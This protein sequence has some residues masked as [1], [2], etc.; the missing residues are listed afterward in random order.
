MPLLDLAS[1]GPWGG[2]FMPPTG[3]S[4]FDTGLPAFDPAAEAQAAREAAAARMTR[5]MRPDRSGFFQLGQVPAYLGEGIFNTPLM[6][7]AGQTAPAAAAPM[8]PPMSAAPALPTPQ[9]VPMLNVKGAEDTALPENSSLTTT[10]PAFPAASIGTGSSST[11][12]A[13]PQTS[14][15]GRIGDTINAHPLTLMALGA[16]IAGSQ[17]FG[18]GI[19]RG[20][21]AA[22]PAMQADTK[23]AGINQTKNALIKRG[24][25]EDVALAASQN[26]A[27]LQQILPQIFGA[28]QRKFTQIGEDMLGNK[29]F[30]FVDEV[31]NKVYGMD[32]NEMT[33]PSAGST[34]PT[35]PD[36]QPL[37]GQNLLTH[38]EKNDP[39]TAAG[40]KGMLEGKENPQSRNLQK[41]APVAS[42]VDP[43]FDAS[44]YPV[45]LATRKNYTSGKQFQELQAINTVAGHLGNLAKSA[46]ALENSSFP[47]LN[48]ARNLYRQNTGDPRVDKFNT[49]K[50]AVSNELSK[51]YR[52]GHVTEGDVR[53]WQ[54]NINAA[55]APPQ[56][57]SVIGEFNDLL[58]SKRQAL[59]DGYRS[60]MGKAP[61]P[62]EFTSVSDHSREVFNR[63]A[64]WSQG[65]KEPAA[66]PTPAAAPPIA[67]A[68]LAPDGKYYIPDPSRGPN[69]YLQVQ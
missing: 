48:Q 56:L 20:L 40:V 63:V 47:I 10:I 33:S 21:T 28:K 61:L 3:A 42:L 53:E 46:D 5:N 62:S 24:I 66:G 54:S 17:N 34:V 41:L 52:G 69:K 64:A 16:G 55:K 29:K 14:I 13:V 8:G 11:T 27:I 38:L 51:A 7:D 36:G 25:P 39:L 59:E 23:Q 58:M 9:N 57:K 49:D 6:P 2:G 31:T 60:S 19:H 4:G 68:K 32:G 43:S 50:Q 12:P 1:L 67:G 26:P 45:R 18:Q 30:G 15:L 35:G 37:S 65:A 22:V 44:Q